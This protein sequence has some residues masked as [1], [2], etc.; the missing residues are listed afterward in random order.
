MKKNVFCLLAGFLLLSF[1]CTSIVIKEK[2]IVEN[3]SMPISFA[4]AAE[5]VLPSVIHINITHK[6]THITPEGWDY[7]FNPF[8]PAPGNIFEEKRNFF[9]EGLGSGVIVKQ[10]GNKFYAVT[11]RHVISD[12]NT[13]SIKLFGG[14]TAEAFSVGFDERKDIAVIYFY[15]DSKFL[16]VV[17]KGNSDLLRIGEWVLAVGSPFGFDSSVTAG[18][19]SALGRRNSAGGNI[20]DFI[21]TDASINTGNSGGALVNTKGEL[22]G[23]NSWITTTT[24]GSMGLGF[25]IPVNNIKRS[26]S[27]IIN[28]G[29]VRYGWIGVIA[30]ELPESERR[31][32][33]LSSIRGVMIFQVIPDGPADLGGLLPGDFIKNING[34]EI[35]TL[36][37][38]LFAVGES[39]QGTQSDFKIIRDGKTLNKKVTLGLRKRNEALIQQNIAYWPGINVMNINRERVASSGRDSGVIITSVERGAILGNFFPG[40]IIAEING[41]SIENSRD[42]YREINK[43]RSFNVIRYYRNGI[44]R[45]KEIVYN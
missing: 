30:G 14:E 5:K 11:N 40:D 16:R 35:P 2:I 38:L 24:G 28:Y 21:Q 41:I 43:N 10:T 23:I 20:S 7:S 4:E 13:I 1:S 18:I 26:I 31:V 3:N 17:E 34:I 6:R 8:S 37:S 32:F 39:K 33:G 19:V 15:S 9:S 25:A 12:A 27:D 22:V 42:F 44:S 29:E 36:D 45:T